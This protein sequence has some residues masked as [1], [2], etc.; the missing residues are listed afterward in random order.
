MTDRD[1]ITPPYESLVDAVDRVTLLPQSQAFEQVMYDH[2]TTRVT[3]YMADAPISFHPLLLRTQFPEPLKACFVSTNELELHDFR[4]VQLIQPEDGALTRRSKMAFTTSGFDYTVTTDGT[5]ATMS[6]DTDN[7]VSSHELTDA[8]YTAFLASIVYA[9]QYAPDVTGTG[10]PDIKLVD[11]PL[12]NRSGASDVDEG[13]TE[14]MIMTLGDFNGRAETITTTVFDT[15]SDIIEAE[16]KSV[17]TPK[18]SGVNNSMKLSRIVGASSVDD[19][20]YQHEVLIPNRLMNHYAESVHRD[21][22]MGEESIRIIEPDEDYEAYGA[23]CA[24]FLAY[25][26]PL[27]APYDLTLE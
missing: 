17:E 19:T 18:M 14:R 3:R 8:D 21:L 16:L 5:T 13:L 22:L 11:D 25:I 2:L 27:M 7:G 15:G 26:Q 6:V 4:V 10:A 1:P 23:I 20:V 24:G 12:L 9:A